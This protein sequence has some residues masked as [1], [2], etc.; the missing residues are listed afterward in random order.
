M[1]L[2]SVNTEM[3]NT[4]AGNPNLLEW[5]EEELLNVSKLRDVRKAFK[6]ITHIMKLCLETLKS[7]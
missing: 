7:N 1:I 4:R 5:V 2:M 3:E 6:K